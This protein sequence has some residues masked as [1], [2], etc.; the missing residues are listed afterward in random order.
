MALVF[1][2]VT[3]VAVVQESLVAAHLAAVVLF[4][5]EVGDHLVQLLLGARAG[6]L[7]DQQRGAVGLGFLTFIV[8]LLIGVV[9]VGERKASAF[10]KVATIALVHEV[11]L[12]DLL[13]SHGVAPIVVETVVCRGCRLSGL[14]NY[15]V[16]QSS[17]ND[18]FCTVRSCR[19]SSAETKHGL[20]GF[21]AMKSCN[22]F[23][24]SP[25]S[26][27]SAAWGEINSGLEYSFSG[28][29]PAS[30]MSISASSSLVK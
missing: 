17:S 1:R 25:R 14:S 24:A 21:D 5:D 15:Y 12:R 27:F 3:V 6:R 18:N 19:L 8:F 10:Q 22:F 16:R 7:R 30:I 29:M 4:G 9:Q 28:L 2:D 13:L 23:F 11:V 20:P 26:N